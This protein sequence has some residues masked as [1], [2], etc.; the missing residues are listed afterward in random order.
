MADLLQS[1]SIVPSLLLLLHLSIFTVLAVQ[2]KPSPYLS[3][4]FFTDYNKML[5]TFKIFV[6]NRDNKNQSDFTSPVKLLFHES[7]LKSPF[8]TTNPDEAHL[9][10]LSFP[11]NTTTTRQISRF[12]NNLR[13]DLPFWNR[14][15]GA[16]HFHLSCNR[17]GPES[18]RNFVELR[19]N[20][21]Q[22]SCFPT[23]EA[24]FIPHKDLSLPPLNPPLLAH[25]EPE[26]MTRTGKL[27]GY[28]WGKDSESTVMD[29]LRDNPE[30]LI[31]SEPSDWN[32][33]A[34]KLS[35]SKFCLFLYNG[36]VFGIGTAFRFG[37]VP[38]VITD[39]PM[40]DL[41][42]SDVLR[43]SE[44][45]VFVGIGGGVAELKSALG[46]ACGDRYERMRELGMQASRHFV[47]NTYPQP[48]DAFHMVLYQLWLSR[49]TIRYV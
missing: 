25:H 44:M 13:T 24:M 1:S 26:L 6:Y 5:E 15:L 32:D 29:E 41:P 7:L 27:L 31:E 47:W 38:L 19:K 39:R 21:V 10:Y 30:F 46:R 40:P 35:S 16:D 17:T 42:F 18:Y 43:W 48:Y 12:I 3:S 2:A 28:F 4:L 14:T 20:S 8:L 23:I 36:D 49:H 45:A 33:Y 11:H 22:I 37:C 34:E 9:F